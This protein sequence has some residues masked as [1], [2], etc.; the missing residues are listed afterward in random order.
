M[1]LVRLGQS[2]CSSPP[3]SS[4]QQRP[5]GPMTPPAAT[6]T[7]DI[8][9][10]CFSAILAPL[11][12]VGQTGKSNFFSMLAILLCLFIS[13]KFGEAFTCRNGSF[14]RVD[15][16]RHPFGILSTPRFRKGL[17]PLPLECGWI[18]DNSALQKRMDIYFTQYYL[19]GNY[20]RIYTNTGLNA[21]SN[22]FTRS[23]LSVTSTASIIYIH[24]KLKTDNLN[25]LH[26]RSPDGIASTANG[27]NITYEFSFPLLESE[28][29]SCSFLDCNLNG[30]CFVHFDDSTIRN[31]AYNDDSNESECSALS[32]SPCAHGGT[33]RYFTSFYIICDCRGNWT[34]PRCTY[35]ASDPYLSTS[36]S[37]SFLCLTT[38]PQHSKNQTD[39]KTHQT[40]TRVCHIVKSSMDHFKNSS[41]LQNTVGNPPNIQRLVLTSSNKYIKTGDEFSLS[42]FVKGSMKPVFE[43]VKD[44]MRINPDVVFDRFL[45]SEVKTVGGSFVGILTIGQAESVDSGIYICKVREDTLSNSLESRISVSVRI[46]STPDIHV[47][48]PQIT[49]IKDHISRLQVENEDLKK[50]IAGLEVELS[51]SVKYA[52]KIRSEASELSRRLGVYKKREILAETVGTQTKE[53]PLKK[54]KR[55]GLEALWDF[56]SG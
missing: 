1:S 40:P 15:A 35:S 32:K 45:K 44:D 31:C 34:G 47:Y 46:F 29:P 5:S 14:I 18:F 51:N 25:E 27:F 8:A 26:I 19:N 38:P 2:W 41:T 22:W 12:E 37:N 16:L 17:L 20:L 11:Q 28:S 50:K 54:E 30:E 9:L 24:L 33:C 42:C 43:W 49:F 13:T 52:E 21:S 4:C 36:L 39:L 7:S 6:E 56:V 23:S 55:G 3:Y 48:P 53:M 10:H